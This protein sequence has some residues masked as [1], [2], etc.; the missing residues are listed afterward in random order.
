M[1]GGGKPPISKSEPDTSSTLLLQLGAHRACCTGPH[2]YAGASI[3]VLWALAASLVPAMAKG[4]DNAR[5]L[6]ITANVINICLFA[7]QLPT[8]FDILT[9]VLANTPWP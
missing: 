9:K 5:T 2:L 3:V 4:N 6:H 7:W 8:G 1:P